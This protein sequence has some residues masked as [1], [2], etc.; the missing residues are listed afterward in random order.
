MRIAAAE[1][2][3]AQLAHLGI[4]ATDR[5]IG[6]AKR[7][8]VAVT[9]EALH[10]LAAEDDDS[11]PLTRWEKLAAVLE[12]GRAFAAKPPPPRVT[13]SRA[14]DARERELAEQAEILADELEEHRALIGDLCD[15]LS[16]R[17]A[18]AKAAAFAT[19]DAQAERRARDERLAIRLEGTDGDPIDVLT[20][21]LAK[22]DALHETMQAQIRKSEAE[23]ARWDR[24]MADIRDALC[25][26][27]PSTA[28][29]VADEVLAQFFG[30]A[31]KP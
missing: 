9:D 14:A 13:V 17:E 19:F 26:A 10:T 31:R 20:D 21:K 25:A 30:V 15:D 12:R 7:R 4:H 28:V 8:G 18:A 6:I 11:P 27:K 3:C 16:A 22:A 24:R 5:L 29:E 1:V 23:A 2:K